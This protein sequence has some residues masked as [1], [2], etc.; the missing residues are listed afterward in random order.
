[1]NGALSQLATDLQAFIA[2]IG[3]G[4]GLSGTAGASASGSASTSA[5]TSVS[6]SGLVTS[7]ASSAS[8]S[9]AASSASAVDSPL[10]TTGADD[11]H[12]FFKVLRAYASYS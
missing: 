4:D 5:T 3:D 1:L 7:S 12:Q 9:S 10:P 11:L 8:A 2:S 6:T